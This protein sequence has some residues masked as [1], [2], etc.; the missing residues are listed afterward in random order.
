[1]IYE[2]NVNTI[3][4][5]DI[6][7]RCKFI[8]YSQLKDIDD[9]ASVTSIIIDNL[10]TEEIITRIANTYIC[11]TDII[12][13]S[14]EE[15]SNFPINFS[16][17]VNLQTL[18]LGKNYICSEKLNIDLSKLT[19][20]KKITW[21]DSVTI[22]GVREFFKFNNHLKEITMF[23]SIINNCYDLNQEDVANISS[24]CTRFMLTP[25]TMN[26]NPV[27]L[28]SKVF[29]NLKSMNNLVSLDLGNDWIYPMTDEMF[30]LENLEELLFGKKWCYELDS[31]ISK[32]IKL[33]KIVF[34]SLYENKIPME[35]IANLVNLQFIQV[36]EIYWVQNKN[37]LNNLKN[38]N[39]NLKFTNYDGIEF[40]N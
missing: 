5:V 26:A 17:L 14:F 30:T 20:L 12:I 3:K 7:N 21:A 23:P 2:S 1:M 27:F 4:N 16:E 13:E 40:T 15:Y 33:K 35:I 6:P 8:K 25:C 34:G 11:T 31:R 29:L 39:V 9:K 10:V 18:E 22:R 19:K 36:S 37:Y 32:F 24:S 28:N 38:I